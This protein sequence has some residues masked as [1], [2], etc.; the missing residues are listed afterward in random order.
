MKISRYIKFP[1]I[2]GLLIILNYL[3]HSSEWTLNGVLLSLIYGAIIGIGLQIYSDYRTRKIK[4][5]AEEKDFSV[6]QKNETVLLCDYEQAF[7]LCRES[8]ESLKRGKVRTADMESGLIEAK[9]GMSWNSFGTVIEFR[10][11]VITQIATEI[12]IIA[13]PLIKTTLI[14][15][16]ESLEAIKTI[17]NFFEKK[18]EEL[19]YKM[20]EANSNIPVDIYDNF[21][22]NAEVK[23]Q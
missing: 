16:G 13:R 1:L 4:A 19:N 2:L 15:Y 23:T 14:D 18:N 8:V 20:L 22:Q 5:G 11:K 10:L 21:L 6:L 9:T 3:F 12:E 7:A 17:N